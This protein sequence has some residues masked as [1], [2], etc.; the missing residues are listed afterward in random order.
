MLLDYHRKGYDL[1]IYIHGLQ[2]GGELGGEDD[3]GDRWVAG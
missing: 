2:S 3:I 1:L